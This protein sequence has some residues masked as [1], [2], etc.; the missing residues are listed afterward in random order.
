M[1]KIL[2][3][4]DSISI[5]EAVENYLK[6]NDFKVISCSA[7]KGVTEIV[8]SESP[9]LAVIDVTLPD[10]NGFF[11]AKEIQSVRKIPFLFLTSR[12]DESDRIMG[13]ELGASD[14]VV[15][16]FSL[17]ELILRIQA[18]LRRTSPAGDSFHNISAWRF[19]GDT[20]EIDRKTHILKLNETPVKLTSM[21]WEIMINLV[22][23]DGAILSR[24]QIQKSIWHLTDDQHPRTIDSHMKNIR[25]KLGNAGWIEAVRSFGF[26]F[27]GEPCHA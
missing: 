21:E 9:D 16:P 27:A 1:E 4:E 25:H 22:S 20:L 14:Y 12:K 5:R 15:K 18:I 26:R 13:L 17:K 8:E 2:L 11:L 6:L 19:G 7:C 24:D 10:G 3:I 23:H